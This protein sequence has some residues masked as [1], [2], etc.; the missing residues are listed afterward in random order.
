MINKQFKFEGKILTVK[1]LKN[2]K[3]KFFMFQGKFDLEN[4]GQGH[5]VLRPL[6]NQYM[7]QV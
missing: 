6:Y 4:Q 3:P 2:L 5:K 1:F 7:D